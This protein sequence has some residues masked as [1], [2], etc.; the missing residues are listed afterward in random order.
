MP[1]DLLSEEVIKEAVKL[2][3]I[4]DYEREVLNLL[5]EDKH[6]FSVEF[7]R[8]MEELLMG[9]TSDL[10][11]R[12]KKMPI[13]YLLVAILIFLMSGMTV[14]AIPGVRDRIAKYCEMLFSDHTDVKFEL[15]AEKTEREEEFEIHKPTYIPK[16][17]KFYEEEYSEEFES[18]WCCYINKQETAVHFW[19]E[20]PEKLKMW[21]ISITSNGD[22]AKEFELNGHPVYHLVDEKG[23]STLI[24]VKEDYIYM[25]SGRV[26]VEELIKILESIKKNRK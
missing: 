9:Y 24:Y 12:R 17:Y 15:P 6:V 7:E 8:K 20:L 18:Y 3:V 10:K 4:R 25:V 13:K 23:A 21:D 19:Q 14:L 2:A 26:N 16:G 11:R 1:T 22:P 5:E